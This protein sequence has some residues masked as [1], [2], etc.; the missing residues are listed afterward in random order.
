MLS[1]EGLSEEGRRN[2]DE[3]NSN[4]MDGDGDNEGEAHIPPASVDSVLG[5]LPENS[6][7]SNV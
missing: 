2:I 6:V 7:L 1:E 3:H 5:K 4:E